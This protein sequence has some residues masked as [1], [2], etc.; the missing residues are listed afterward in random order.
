[1][2]SSQ[3]CFSNPWSHRV[4]QF[5]PQ[6]IAKQSRAKQTSDR[7]VSEQL[8][9]HHF[10]HSNF[11][12]SVKSSVA[13]HVHFYVWG[14]RLSLRSLV[15]LS[16]A[17]RRLVAR[18][19]ALSFRLRTWHRRRIFQLADNTFSLAVLTGLLYSPVCNSIRFFL[20]RV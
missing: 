15:F 12:F 14:F 7:Y 1:M 6:T 16:L 11:C 10:V 9:F 20:S 8:Y 17:L 13:V 2:D 4:N 5:R 3:N 19:V 18:V